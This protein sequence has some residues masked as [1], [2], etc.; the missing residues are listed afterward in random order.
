MIRNRFS[1]NRI[2]EFYRFSHT[3]LNFSSEF[4]G[5]NILFWILTL[6][7][8]WSR[9][10]SAKMFRIGPDPDIHHF[11]SRRDLCVRFSSLFSNLTIFLQCE[12]LGGAILQQTFIV[13]YTVAYQMCSDC[14]RVE[15]KVT[16]HF[17]W[18]NILICRSESR[19]RCFLTPGPGIRIRD[20]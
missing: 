8:F 16:K 15:A 11:F 19:I 3:K 9:T 18:D 5:R 4:W 20:G 13:E 12:V 17:G 14:H 2:S 6:I 10:Q 7:L 1:V